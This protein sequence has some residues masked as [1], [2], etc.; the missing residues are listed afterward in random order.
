MPRKKQQHP[1]FV[2]MEDIVGLW[3]YLKSG[4]NLD[5]VT[6]RPIINPSVRELIK[7]SCENEGAKLKYIGGVFEPGG[8]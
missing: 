6:D 3:L 2:Y 4:D 5:L 8:D 1:K 7:Q